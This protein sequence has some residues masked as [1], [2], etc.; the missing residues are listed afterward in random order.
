MGIRAC[1]VKIEDKIREILERISKSRT[2]PLN[3]IQRA[4][5]ILMASKGKK[6]NE[7]GEAVN[8]SQDKVSKWR[9]RFVKE[10]EYL[11]NVAQTKPEELEEAVEEF[12][13]DRPRSGAPCEFTEIQIIQILEMACRNPSEFGYE[14]SHRNTPKLAEAVAKA[15]IVDTI[16]P[17]SVNRFLKYGRYTAAQG[18]LLASLNGKSRQPGNICGKDK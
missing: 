8:L 7:I 11:S 13:R 14:L 17:S 1:E 6:N 9:C 5:A 3:Q 4:K 12:L 15:G 16:S 2:K 10:A 18:A